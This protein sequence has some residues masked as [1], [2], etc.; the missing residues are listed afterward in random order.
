LRAFS[1]SSFSANADSM[2]HCLLL[3][4]L[5]EPS[6]LS[7]KGKTNNFKNVFKIFQ[8]TK[9]YNCIAVFRIRIIWPLI[10]LEK[11]R[12]TFLKIKI[13]NNTI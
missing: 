10:Y 13:D 2:L 7:L 12:S 9:T 3:G 5:G 4:V 11:L 8:L 6:G 1:W